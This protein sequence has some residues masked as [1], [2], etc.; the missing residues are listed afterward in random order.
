L[1]V[2]S[3]LQRPATA[4]AVSEAAEGEQSAP[5]EDK[6]EAEHGDEVAPE[7]DGEPLPATVD[8][9][10]DAEASTIGDLSTVN[11]SPWLAMPPSERARAKQRWL[12]SLSLYMNR[13]HTTMQQMHQAAE[14]YNKGLAQMQRD[15]LKFLQN[16]DEKTNI[17]EDYLQSWPSRFSRRHSDHINE[18]VDELSDH[19]WQFANK[20]RSESVEE[21]TRLAESG[22]W[23]QHAGACV[24]LGAEL[25]SLECGRYK[26]A[27]D[28]LAVGFGFPA[29]A[30]ALAE[31]TVDASPPESLSSVDDFI[32]W[33]SGLTENIACAPLPLPIEGFTDRDDD[34]GNDCPKIFEERPE[35]RAALCAAVGSEKVVLLQR[36]HAVQCWVEARLGVMWEQLREAFAKMDDWIRDRVGVENDAI[37]SATA[38][39]LD[40]GWS[41]DSE[42]S[43]T[44]AKSFKS[45]K[46]SKAFGKSQKRE[47]S[48]SF[49]ATVRRKRRDVLNALYPVT[50]DV[51]ILQPPKL[52]VASIPATQLQ[53]SEKAT[54]RKSVSGADSSSTANRW[55]QD[56]LLGLAKNL[57]ER[58]G[59]AAAVSSDTF[60]AALL[61]QRSSGFGFDV[62]MVPPSFVSRSEALLAYFSATLVT[63]AWGNI[64]VDV[65]EILLQL[66]FHERNVPWPTAEALVAARGLIESAA[67]GLTEEQLLAYPDVPV[68]EELFM[69]LPLWDDQ[70]QQQLADEQPAER[71][72]AIKIWIFRILLFFQDEAQPLLP[73]AS[74]PNPAAIS[75]RRLFTYLGLAATPMAG[76]QLALKLLI[77]PLPQKN[78]AEGEVQEDAIAKIRVQHLWF[79][80]FSTQ[81]RSSKAVAA[82]PTLADF[83]AELLPPDE[84]PEPV[85]AAKA[86]PKGKPGKGA[87]TPEP[88]EEEK[89]PPPPPEEMTVAF[90]EQLMRNKAILRGLCTHGGLLSMRRALDVLCPSA[91]GSSPT[92]TT[93]LHDTA[94]AA[95]ARGLESLVPPPA[96]P[97]QPQEGDGA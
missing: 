4:A 49:D 29:V 14:T 9:A 44:S 12:E 27:G 11:G 19:L 86:A 96:P 91:S 59:A 95:S 81:G 57:T 47:S 82:P 66:T 83:C 43:P 10:E 69:Q 13:L 25:Y 46:S 2:T 88:V 39:L 73:S 75:A 79:I 93:A 63:P 56:M 42:L 87:P 23:E 18:E 38:L 55:T 61:E 31:D 22:F 84:E 40:W 60:L 37:K 76:L 52:E 32:S 68:S 7:D 21:H 58:S 97:E 62:D 67:S 77:S 89:A 50:L 24:G 1:E 74:G 45:S 34:D 80:L 51:Q 8:E 71:L 6:A 17:M 5:V 26:V 15:F 28:L 92:S 33:I 85:A 53:L 64:A 30:G 65:T 78:D 70:V 72:D 90:D 41:E 20:R 3:S 94:A 36:L 48:S 16:T 35:A 54:S